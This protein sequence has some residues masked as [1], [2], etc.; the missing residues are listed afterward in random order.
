VKLQ[1]VWMLLLCI[2]LTGCANETTPV[3]DAVNGDTNQP[4]STGPGSEPEVIGGEESPTQPLLE[5]QSR[6]ADHKT[7][8]GEFV[9]MYSNSREAFQE[10]YRGKSVEVTG[11]VYTLGVDTTMRTLFD[12]K[13][14]LCTLKDESEGFT[15]LNV[16]DCLNCYTP[17]LQ[18]WK[19]ISP[20]GTATVRGVADDGFLNHCTIVSVE[21]TPVPEIAAAEL[22]KQYKANPDDVA[23][24]YDGQLIVV[25]GSLKSHGDSETTLVGEGGI[26]ITLLCTPSIG[27]QFRGL[28]PGDPVAAIGECSFFGVDADT[29]I[30]LES[31]SRCEV[32][33]R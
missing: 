22:A 18:P 21:G 4:Q 8:V 2:V 28:K 20:G 24:K 25:T 30:V 16:D 31:C 26:D 11:I 10:K 23:K 27:M 17:G 1:E 7:T 13:I 3:V 6:T 15:L 29:P 12:P 9:K 14:M 19:Q 32:V 5:P 33:D